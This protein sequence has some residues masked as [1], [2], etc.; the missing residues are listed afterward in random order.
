MKWIGAAISITLL[1]LTG[2]ASSRKL[3]EMS[4]QMNVLEQQNSA[5]EDKLIE[6]DSLGRALLDALTIFKARTEF[7]E[8]AGDARLEEMSAKLN[9]VIDRVERLQQS[10]AALQQGLLKSPS[11]IPAGDSAADTAST[12][13]VVYVDP[14][15]LYDAAFGDIQAGNYQLAILGFNEYISGFPNT[16]RTDDAQFWIGEC[17]YRQNDFAAAKAEYLKVVNKYP[18]SDKM[19][20]A[21]YKLGKCFM[22]L[23]DKT[24]AKK[25]YDQTIERFPDTAEAELAKQQRGTLGD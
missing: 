22:E 15:K 25:Y 10:V 1:V 8:L 23:G 9:D 7:T 6:V 21:L 3:D 2:C 5:I 18:Q 13:G 24:Q 16:D 19:A 11:P 12:E 17:Y 4:L 20:S 14:K